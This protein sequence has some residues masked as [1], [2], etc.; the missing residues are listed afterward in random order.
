[1]LPRERVK[2]QVAAPPNQL[3]P[4]GIA[5]HHRFGR[6]Q[7]KPYWRRM[8]AF[9]SSTDGGLGHPFVQPAEPETVFRSDMMSQANPIFA[10][11]HFRARAF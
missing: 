2:G 8:F 10:Y 9:Y 7:T 3:R 6:G 5:G 1:M 4:A 11:R